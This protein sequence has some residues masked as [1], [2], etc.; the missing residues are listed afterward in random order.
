MRFPRWAI[1]ALALLLVPL[2]YAGLVTQSGPR[3]YVQAGG[4]DPGDPLFFDDFEYSISRTTAPAEMED[5]FQL[6]GWSGADA[7]NG[8]GDDTGYLYTATTADIDGF[9]G[10]FPSGTRVLAMEGYPNNASNTA[11]LQTDYYVAYGNAAGAV[12]QVPPDAWIQTWI[13]LQNSGSQLSSYPNRNKFLYPTMDGGTGN[14]DPEQGPITAPWLVL[15]GAQGYEAE[16]GPREEAFLAIQAFGARRDSTQP[17]SGDDN[18]LYQ[19]VTTSKKLVENA[20]HLIKLHI[21][22]STANGSAEAWIC[23]EGDG[24]FTKVMEWIVGT[25]ANFQWTTYE[26][27]RAGMRVL[28]TPTTENADPQSNPARDGYGNNIKFLDD[29][30]LADAEED[31]PRYATCG[32]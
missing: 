1:A 7:N 21:D 2:A 24:G 25:T 22:T 28:K 32:G 4:D 16:M 23:T 18:K 29:F 17:V 11:F 3:L 20:W 30:A 9:S 12:G 13:Y 8:T 31:L 26:E 19:N 27:T 6:A 5:A 10:S 15:L 14:V